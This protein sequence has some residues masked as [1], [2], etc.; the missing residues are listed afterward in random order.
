MVP[1]ARK[2]ET[3]LVSS[4]A[5]GRSLRSESAKEMEPESEREEPSVMEPV[6]LSFEA[7]MTGASLAPV[8]VRMRL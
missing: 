7:V 8:M 4:V 3:D 5:V 6:M 2:A 1:S